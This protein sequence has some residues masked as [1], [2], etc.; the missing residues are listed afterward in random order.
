MIYGITLQQPWAWC[1][2]HAGKRIENRTWRPWCDN[3]TYLAIHAGK[4]IDRESVED[5]RSHGIEVPP[6]FETSVAVAQLEGCAQSDTGVPEDQLEW[7][8]GPFAWL[9]C[10]VVLI[11]PL[12]CRGM[13]GL[14]TIPP[15]VLA[16][17]RDRWRAG[18]RI[19]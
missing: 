15:P 17:L 7:W 14:W 13:Q 10:N 16:D 8:S 2:A 1:I 3:G 4:T 5:L 18:R 6:Q 9:L 12:P 19:P 11:D